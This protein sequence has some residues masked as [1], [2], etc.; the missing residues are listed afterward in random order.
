MKWA[1]GKQVLKV[2]YVLGNETARQGPADFDYARTAPAAIK[3]GVLVNAI[4]C[5]NSGGQE[6]WREFA[7]M[8]D[9][10]YLEIGGQG[11]AVV[12][13][14]PFDAELEKL[15]A[16]L[17]TTYVPFGR[18][19]EVR[20]RNQAVQDTAAK[21]FGAPAAAE[22]SLAKA[23]DQYNARLWDLVDASRE[24]D[25]DWAKVKA[26]EL[27]PEMQKMT[28]EERKAYVAKKAGERA[29]IQKEVRELGQKRDAFVQDEIKK[30][31]LK[32]AGTFDDAVRKSLK[33]Q[34]EKKGFKF[35]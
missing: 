31:G 19:G 7:R 15:S 11:G 35:K 25:F 27:P 3:E 16:R 28:V 34:A 8:A 33:E 26:T 12:V 6:T 21:R 13:K 29:A 14:T 17:N 4:Y 18:E 22:R 32:T 5:G 24:K 2:I 1:R 9:G 23:T 20:Q 10:S 30:Q